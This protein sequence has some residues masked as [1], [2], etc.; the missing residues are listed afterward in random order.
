MESR[1]GHTPGHL[2][3]FAPAAKL[4]WVGD[5]LF[6]HSI[7]RCDFPGGNHAALLDSIKNKLWPLGGDTCFIPGHGPMSTFAEERRHNPYVADR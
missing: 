1:P 2:V 5:V 7:G 4:A 6:R 3:F